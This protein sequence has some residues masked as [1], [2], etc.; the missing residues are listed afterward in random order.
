MKSPLGRLN[1]QFEKKKKKSLT[2]KINI[3][4]IIFYSV[5]NKFIRKHV[6]ICHC[7]YLQNCRVRDGGQYS[8]NTQDIINMAIQV[9]VAGV[10]LHTNGFYHKDLAARNCV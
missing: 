2:I 7:R 10:F 3:T 6:L 9:A 4:S 1:V 8:L 5:E